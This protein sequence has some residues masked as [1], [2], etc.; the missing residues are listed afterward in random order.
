MSVVVRVQL[1]PPSSDRETR[2]F[3][4][5]SPPPRPA[6]PRPP[7]PPPP[8]ASIT[9]YRRLVSRGAIAISALTMS[10]SPFRSCVQFLPPSVDLKMPPPVP[11]HAPFSHGPCRC[12]H[13]V[14]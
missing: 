3:G 7:P 2:G 9:A 6:P 4:T 14:A 5:G 13:I 12:S 8:A 10:G 11:L 1:S